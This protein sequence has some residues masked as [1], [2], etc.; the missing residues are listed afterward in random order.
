MKKSFFVVGAAILVFMLAACNQPVSLEPDRPGRPDNLTLE[1]SASGN[2]AIV[3]WT[4]GRNAVNHQIVK[5]MGDH[6]PIP[7]EA[8]DMKQ[9]GQ[10][11]W[12]G[13]LHVWA[14][15]SRNTDRWSAVITL[16]SDWQGDFEIGVRA[17]PFDFVLGTWT[18]SDV[19]WLGRAES[20]SNFV[21]V[22]RIDWPEDSLPPNA[23][24]DLNSITAVYPDNATKKEITWK[25]RAG[26]VGSNTLNQR[27]GASD[28]LVLPDGLLPYAG[29]FTVQGIVRGGIDRGQNDYIDAA[30]VITV[31]GTER[32]DPITSFVTPTG[33]LSGLL[34][35]DVVIVG[36]EYDLNELAIIGSSNATNQTITWY[37]VF[38][39]AENWTSI[40]NGRFVVPN[41]GTM[42]R[43][44]PLS[45]K[46][47]VTSGRLWLTDLDADVYI[48][49]YVAGIVDPFVPVS[50]VT[51]PPDHTF[52]QRGNHNLNAVA[53]V[54]PA[55][56]TNKNIEWSVQNQH[57]DQWGNPDGWSPWSII[58]DGGRWVPTAFGDHRLR[59][60]I[61]RGLGDAGYGMASSD[62]TREIPIYV[63]P[64]AEEDII[65]VTSVT[66]SPRISALAGNEINLNAFTVIAPPDATNKDIIWDN[67]MAWESGEEWDPIA[68][69]PVNGVFTL[70]PNITRLLVAG[71]IPDG[72][73]RDN[74]YIFLSTIYVM[75]PGF[76]PVQEFE[77]TWHITDVTARTVVN[78]NSATYVTTRIV[79]ANATNRAITWEFH[80]AGSWVEI[81]DG[82]WTP[83]RADIFNVR[84][85]IRSGHTP[86]SDIFSE[87]VLFNA[88]AA[89]G[90]VPATSINFGSPNQTAGLGDTVNLLA[91][92][93]A[94]AVMPTNATNQTIRW[95]IVLNT[96]DIGRGEDSR[97]IPMAAADSA[98]TLV[99]N[100]PVTL[101]PWERMSRLEITATIENGS[102][103]G[104]NLVINRYIDIAPP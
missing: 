16:F 7:V 62:Y 42:P 34:G 44:T 89:Y 20:F 58:P 2:R 46:A 83:P 103:P 37:Y 97:R 88:G 29:T 75:P 53:T 72:V 45:L 52:T 49:G 38:M 85:R 36:S 98:R 28:W 4:A 35:K 59:V 90:F 99:L 22:E 54:S 77:I 15:D 48:F 92:A 13:E 81:P 84:A 5:R 12:Q 60:T 86:G 73:D 23:P 79:P 31:S 61:R 17:V 56:A 43:P 71:E 18:P 47:V 100:P 76:I 101:Y 66:L 65:S 32:Y 3:S 11:S 10:Y 21:P 9:G 39:G 41:P 51:I 63:R 6:N 82:N 40:P 14:Y 19:R 93:P 95:T 67:V 24:L 33:N 68:L 8:I 25:I 50:Y 69:S 94:A 104:V 1:L 87:P 80:E 26:D 27:P 96:R 102:G 70:P 57:V 78:L 74:A 55:N 91:L 64:V 30:H